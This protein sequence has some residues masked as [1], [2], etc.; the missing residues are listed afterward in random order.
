MI[1]LPI[2]YLVLRLGCQPPMVLVVAFALSVLCLA[3]RVYM[4]R[5]MINLKAKEFVV[6]VYIRILVVTIVSSMAPLALY[7]YYN[8]GFWAFVLNCIACLVSS[9]LFIYLIGCNNE[10]RTF[11][12]DKLKNVFTTAE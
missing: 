5:G 11:L 2:S 6:N 4:L 1:N 9:T 10:E 7:F 8:D 3:A 12:N